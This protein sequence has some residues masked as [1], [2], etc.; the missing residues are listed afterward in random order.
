MCFSGLMFDSVVKGVQLLASVFVVLIQG[1]MCTV[2]A[3][4]IILAT[5]Q[6]LHCL[7]SGSSQ[8][9]ELLVIV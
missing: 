5:C 1:A 9:R 3:S 4:G 6:W 7:N 2:V 8:D